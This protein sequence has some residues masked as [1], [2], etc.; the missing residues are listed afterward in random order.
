[1][2]PHDHEG[3]AKWYERVPT[4]AGG[5]SGGAEE[6]RHIVGDDEDEE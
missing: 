2:L 6:T 5:M 1:M 3:G 4:T